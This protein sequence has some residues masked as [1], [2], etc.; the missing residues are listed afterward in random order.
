[1]QRVWRLGIEPDTMYDSTWWHRETN[2]SYHSSAFST[3]EDV[4]KQNK[5]QYYSSFLRRTIRAY[6]SKRRVETFG[7]FQ[8]HPNSLQIVITVLPQTFPY[9]NT[10]MNVMLSLHLGYRTHWCVLSTVY[11][12]L[13]QILCKQY[14]GITQV[15]LGPILIITCFYLAQE[16]PD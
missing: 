12:V 5:S 13:S 10:T 6:W 2:A 1:M 7:S 9:H 8:N 15:G 16:N 11:S 3:R 4:S 14:T